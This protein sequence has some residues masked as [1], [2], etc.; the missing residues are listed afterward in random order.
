M[1]TLRR[2]QRVRGVSARAG[3]FIPLTT[4]KT[5]QIATSGLRRACVLVGARTVV[6]VLI[7]ERGA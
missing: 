1:P 7:A 4:A 5:H 6:R 2:G 3:V